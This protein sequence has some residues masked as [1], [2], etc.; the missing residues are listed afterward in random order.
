VMDDLLNKLVG[1][2][3]E[4][5]VDAKTRTGVEK[6]ALVV[7]ASY[8]EG[9]FERVRFGQVGDAAY[10]VRDGEAGIAKIDM[11]SLRSAL[12]AFD[13]AVTPK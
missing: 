4:S 12:Q 13:V 1:I 11:M 8:D 9:K 5:F 6:P 10:G 2:K 7:S 3:A